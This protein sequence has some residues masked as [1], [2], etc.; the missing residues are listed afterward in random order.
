[1]AAPPPG[2]G[3]PPPGAP[4]AAPPPGLG[5]PPPAAPPPGGYG[6]PPP[7]PGAPPAAPPPAAPPAGP[8]A[9]ATVQPVG[10]LIDE[11]NNVRIP[12][13]ATTIFGRNPEADP[14]VLGGT[15]ATV[16]IDEPGIEDIHARIRIDGAATTVES[17]GQSTVSITRAGGAAGAQTVGPV[18][19]SLR[20]GDSINIGARA[21]VFQPTDV[22]GPR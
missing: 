22:G 18:A 10:Y 11:P 21:F 17:V 9:G 7:A 1:P 20:A 16:A 13:T 8:G 2:L 12:I 4:P 15:A 14:D 6:A 19:V 5:T 3:T